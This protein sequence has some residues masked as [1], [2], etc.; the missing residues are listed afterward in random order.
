MTYKEWLF[1]RLSDIQHE[2]DNLPEHREAK[3]KR[4]DLQMD[5]AFYNTAQEAY[6]DFEN[7]VEFTSLE[8]KREAF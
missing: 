6:T 3:G 1:K 2:I 5:L 7:E 4:G 8:T